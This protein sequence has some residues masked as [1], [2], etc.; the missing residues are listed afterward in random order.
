MAPITASAYVYWLKSKRDQARFS[1]LKLKLD[2]MQ[3]AS[4]LSKF[5]EVVVTTFDNAKFSGVEFRRQCSIV[6]SALEMLDRNYPQTTY[7]THQRVLE[8]IAQNG[9]MLA[10]DEAWRDLRRREAAE[11]FARRPLSTNERG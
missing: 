2:K 3:G 1:A 11:V 6:T 4:S 5:A 10:L 8:W 7:E 9:G